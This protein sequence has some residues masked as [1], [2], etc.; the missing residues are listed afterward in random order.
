[1]D[2]IIG[3]VFEIAAMSEIIYQLYYQKLVRANILM[4]LF[5]KKIILFYSCRARVQTKDGEYD[6]IATNDVITIILL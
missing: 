5:L 2:V 3:I 1:M 4:K 6:T